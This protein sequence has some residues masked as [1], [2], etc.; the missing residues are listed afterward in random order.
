MGLIEI[1]VLLTDGLVTLGEMRSLYLLNHHPSWLSWV[2]YLSFA[3]ASLL[4]LGIFKSR[5]IFPFSGSRRVF[6]SVAF[7]ITLLT[8]L[9]NEFLNWVEMLGYSN[10]YRLGLSIICGSY[11]LALLFIGLMKQVK[12]LR[13][14]A[15]VLF[16][17]IITKLF[18][19]DL[20]SLTTIAKT[21]VMIILGVL[22]LAAS[23][24]YNK[25]ISINAAKEN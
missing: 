19:Y 4:W 10:Q 16:A 17:L 11:A 13:I 5:Q 2:R 14:I 9:C 20:Q 22:L 1:G 3:A 23:F 12:H 18:V 21:I 15:I 24:L 7:N 8:I 25:Y 6:L